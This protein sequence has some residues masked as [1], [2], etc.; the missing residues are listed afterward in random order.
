MY[1]S[2]FVVITTPLV[3]SF[4][5]DAEIIVTAEGVPKPV[6]SEDEHLFRS[7]DKRY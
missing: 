7:E 4:V 2:N 1:C 5:T 3:L 6:S